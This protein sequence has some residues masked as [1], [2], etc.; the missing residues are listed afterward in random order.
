MQRIRNPSPERRLRHIDHLPAH[1]TGEDKGERDLV[2]D[3]GSDPGG[4]LMVQAQILAGRMRDVATAGGRQRITVLLAASIYP[5]LLL[6]VFREH[7]APAYPFPA[8]EYRSPDDAWLVMAAVIAAVLPA[9]FLPLEASRP[10]AVMVWI[11]YALAYV[12]SQTMPVVRFDWPPT[13]FLWLQLGLL[14][15][16]GILVV[17]DRLPLI[18][19]PAPR[20]PP[21]LFWGAFWTAYVACTSAIVWY[22]GVPK[23]IPTFGEVYDVRYDFIDRIEAMPDPLAY[24]WAWQGQVFNPFLVA[25]G[26]ARKSWGAFAVGALGQVYLYGVAGEKSQLFS[27]G[28]I[29]GVFLLVRFARFALG[30]IATL[31]VVTLIPA[32]LALDTLLPTPWFMALFIHRTMVTPGLL[33]GAFY[34][35]FS[36]NPKA[37]LGYS[38]LAPF[39]DYP[40]DTTIPYVM[41]REFFDSPQTVAN[42]NLW[43][44]GFANFGFAGIVL[45][46]LIAGGVM[47]TFNVVSRGERLV[48][49]AL[50]GATAAMVW[51]NISVFTSMLTHGIPLTLILLWIVPLRGP[52]VRTVEESRR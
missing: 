9:L 46:S 12:P 39:V 36:D 28:L 16:M 7:V 31:G 3:D 47:W 2:G 24:L 26:L 49:G 51:T 30:A 45:V 13:D 32:S 48:L 22:V 21:R 43:A 40:Y 50:L 11:I 19:L 4:V 10:G 1:R 6:W 52:N 15:G 17:A 34:E 18:R 41:G 29:V 38:V 33:T 27:V 20:L 5:I 25:Y 23:Q 8:Y 14:A 42:A 44:D 37:M 35:F